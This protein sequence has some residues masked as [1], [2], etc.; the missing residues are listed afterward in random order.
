LSGQATLEGLSR[1]L[2]VLGLELPIIPPNSGPGGRS[3]EKHVNLITRLRGEQGLF[4]CVNPYAA[5]VWFH[6]WCRS[7]PLASD[8]ETQ[9]ARWAAYL[10]NTVDVNTQPPEVGLAFFKLDDEGNLLDRTDPSHE[11]L[12]AAE[13]VVLSER[14]QQHSPSE[15]SRTAIALAAAT[16]VLALTAAGLLAAVLLDSSKDVPAPTDPGAVAREVRTAATDTNSSSGHVGSA[17]QDESSADSSGIGHPTARSPGAVGVRATIERFWKK[18]E[19]RR[20]SSAYADLSPKLQGDPAIGSESAWV[21]RQ[22]LNLLQ[23]SI[24]RVRPTNVRERTAQADVARLRTQTLRL[25][26]QEWSGLYTLVR[27]RGRW[28]ID[29]ASLSQLPC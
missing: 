24:V 21:A 28:L 13:V 10:L 27:P 5:G 22:E 23:S 14:T 9:A 1:Y 6:A 29:S 2:R 12:G 15:W 3:P 7:H 16:A 26:C 8:A 19:D 25:G 20:L 11:P 17:A 4:I 18:R